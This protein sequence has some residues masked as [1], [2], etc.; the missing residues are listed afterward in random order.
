M[1]VT[2]PSLIAS[3][4]YSTDA[5]IAGVRIAQK[6]DF[7]WAYAFEDFVC[8]ADFHVKTLVKKKP[9]LTGDSTVLVFLFSR[10]WYGKNEQPC[11]VHHKTMFAQYRVK[12]FLHQFET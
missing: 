4:K 11:S 9:E 7:F 6:L 3:L 10:E 5:A 1:G 8:C 2:Q 12:S